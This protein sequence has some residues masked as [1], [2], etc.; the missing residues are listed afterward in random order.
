MAVV[1]ERAVLSVGLRSDPWVDEGQVN[2]PGAL[3]RCVLSR[4]VLL[5]ESRGALLLALVRQVPRFYL[6]SFV[7]LPFKD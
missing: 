5:L 7:E 1:L 3:A 6:V 4:F 2:L